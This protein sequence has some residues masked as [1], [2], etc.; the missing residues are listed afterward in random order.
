MAFED[1]R[2]RRSRLSSL[3]FCSLI[4]GRIWYIAEKVCGCLECGSC[5]G[6]EST[7]ALFQRRGGREGTVRYEDGRFDVTVNAP[8]SKGIGGAIVRLDAARKVIGVI[9]VAAE[10]HREHFCVE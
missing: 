8:S 7:S 9:V 5:V 3:K 4:I 2:F 1:D 6:S 10:M